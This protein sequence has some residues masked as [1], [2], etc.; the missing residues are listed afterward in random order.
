MG[1]RIIYIPESKKI[2][3]FTSH[4]ASASTVNVFF[5]VIWLAIVAHLYGEHR[6]RELDVV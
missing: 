3:R 6:R 1:N 4:P 2:E 5:V